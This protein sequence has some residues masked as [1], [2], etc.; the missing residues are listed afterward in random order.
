M[1]GEDRLVTWSGNSVVGE[2]PGKWVGLAM[3][4][5]GQVV[6]VQPGQ[7]V[8]AAW[9]VGRVHGWSGAA[10]ERGAACQWWAAWAVGGV[11]KGAGLQG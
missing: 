11:E 5:P 8:R 9:S 1:K 10:G 4:Q 6:K 2:Q 3:G 7:F